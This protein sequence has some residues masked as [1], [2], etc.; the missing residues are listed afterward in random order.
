LTCL[1][2]GIYHVLLFGVGGFLDQFLTGVFLTPLGWLPAGT[3]F[4]VIPLGLAGFRTLCS[5]ALA[6]VS[7]DIV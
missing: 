3:I 5:D 6:I 2:G 4:R 7:N 1:T